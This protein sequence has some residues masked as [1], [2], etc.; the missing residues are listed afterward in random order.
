MAL[1]RQWCASLLLQQQQQQQKIIYSAATAAVAGAN[2]GHQQRNQSTTTSAH[3]DAC[4]PLE[5]P[6]ILITGT[7][8]AVTVFIINSRPIVHVVRPSKVIIR[9]FDRTGGFI[10]FRSPSADDVLFTLSVYF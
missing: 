3:A 9:S 10:D 6:R 8:V 4:S 7:S 1:I 5:N 2:G